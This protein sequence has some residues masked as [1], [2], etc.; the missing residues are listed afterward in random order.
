MQGILQEM[1]RVRELVQVYESLPNGAGVF[2]SKVLKGKIKQAEY[3]I[4]SDD[5][6]EMIQVYNS[7]KECE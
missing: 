2:G 1:N 7:L 3:A 6:L 5:V 4:G